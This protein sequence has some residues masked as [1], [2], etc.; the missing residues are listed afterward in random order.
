MSKGL[1]ANQN[2]PRAV[3]DQ[4]GWEWGVMSFAGHE[5]SSLSQNSFHQHLL[6]RCAAPGHGTDGFGHNT[7]MMGQREGAVRDR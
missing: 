6:F 5:F 3:M 7:A 1:G 4:D 2:T